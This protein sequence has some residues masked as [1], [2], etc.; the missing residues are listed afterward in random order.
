MDKPV[1]LYG[2]AEL[3]HVTRFADIGDGLRDEYFVR[4]KSYLSVH[5]KIPFQGEASSET[6]GHVES[7]GQIQI[8]ISERIYNDLR[9]QM[10]TAGN[11][12]LKIQGQLEF[13]VESLME[14][15]STTS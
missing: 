3:V 6:F 10:K 11:G 5:P 2:L 14:S 12:T 1:Y 13:T 4:V 9:R 8:P 7:S 15:E